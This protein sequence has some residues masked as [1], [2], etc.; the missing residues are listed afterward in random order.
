MLFRVLFLVT[1]IVAASALPF[2]I[3]APYLIPNKSF[4]KIGLSISIFRLTSIS[5]IILAAVYCPFP[6]RMNPRNFSLAWVS[7]EYLI[8]MDNCSCLPMSF[9]SSTMRV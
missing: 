6:R 2:S 8:Q 3:Y 7:V 9:D 5:F 1:A 4:Q